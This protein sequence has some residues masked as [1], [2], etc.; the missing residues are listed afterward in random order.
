VIL[1]AL[2]RQLIDALADGCFHSGVELSQALN[3]TRATVSNR[4]RHLE[5]VG[6]EV[7]SVHG[8][9]Y[10]LFSPIERLDEDHIRSHFSEEA[11][12]LCQGF[13]HLDVIDSTN[14]Y[15]MEQAKRG[16]PSGQVCVAEHQMQGRGRM[17][18]NWVS[19]YG[20]NLY[21]SVLWRFEQV[22]QVQGLS[23]AVGVV[24]ARALQGVLGLDRV[25]LKWPNDIW[26]DG[27]KLGGI[28]IEMAGEVHG[29]AALVLGVGINGR[30]PQSADP[31]IDQAWTDLERSGFPLPGK[32][33]LLVSRILS[34]LFTLLHHYPVSGLSPYLK[35]F[36]S[37]HGAAGQRAQILAGSSELE[38]TILDV[39]DQGHLLMDLGSSGIREFASGEVRFRVI[40]S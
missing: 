31:I 28:L 32:R 33:N 4:V 14:T 7:A 24:V 16:V 3:V 25:Q 12:Q 22:S 36:R 5:Q 17:G 38:G 30:L 2:D 23:L 34:G 13:T 1:D 29:S 21:L 20:H 8:R 37:L 40:S 19:A 11:I 27:K 35:T 9:G 18:R 15:L 10:R 26:L 6:L 39:N